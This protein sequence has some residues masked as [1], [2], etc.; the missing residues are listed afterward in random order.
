MPTLLIQ[1]QMAD[2]HPVLFPQLPIQQLHTRMQTLITRIHGLG[3]VQLRHFLILLD[4]VHLC[5]QGLDLRP[6]L[7]FIIILSN[8][9][10]FNLS[11]FWVSS[12]RGLIDCR[13]IVYAYY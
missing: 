4:E 9:K 2:L 5:C 10:L 11:H 3:N 6:L 13:T 12:H 8:H 1:S 7:H